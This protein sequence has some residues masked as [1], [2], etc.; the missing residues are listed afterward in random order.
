MSDPLP[1]W[2][3][4][5]STATP[6]DASN[7]NEYTTAITDNDTAISTLQSQVGTLN[8][9]VG[10]LTTN[11]T[12]LQSATYVTSLTAADSTVTVAGTSSAPTVKV[13][14]A[15][16]TLA[17]SQ[18]TNLS[19]DLAASYGSG[20]RWAPNVYGNQFENMERDDVTAGL[21]MASGSARTWLILLGLCPASTY[22][23]FKVYL[24]TLASGSGVMTCA[25]YSG[26][27]IT[28]TSWARLGSGNVTTPSLTSATGIISTSLS[29]TLASPA[30]VALEMVATTT[31]ATTYPTFAGSASLGLSGGSGFMNPSSSCPVFGTLNAS[32]A[33][34][35]TLNP[36]TGFIAGTQKIW[37]ALA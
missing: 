23:S 19:S 20:G 9:E 21:L 33:P 1:T 35:S 37:C 30:Y 25:L 11:V 36:T 5:P 31:W 4:S 3:D 28:S 34:A 17:Q 14:Q 29:F 8:T 26:S 24:S 18:V 15:N 22:S 32:T 10:T 2:S 16:L 7:L 12:A 27:S 13:A 6:L